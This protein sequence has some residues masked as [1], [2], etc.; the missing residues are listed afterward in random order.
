MN[1]VLSSLHPGV[2]IANAD[3]TV[4]LATYGTISSHFPKLEYAS[5]L[6]T[7]YVLAM[8]AAQPIVGVRFSLKC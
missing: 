4:V 6:V 1:T 2:F 5:W 3:G 8:C 7:S